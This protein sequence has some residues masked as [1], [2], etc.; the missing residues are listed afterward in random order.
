MKA[1]VIHYLYYFNVPNVLYIHLEVIKI[2]C[3]LQQNEH[4][5]IENS[6]RLWFNLHYI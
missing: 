4:F 5:T 1:Y 6:L 2:M 3:N